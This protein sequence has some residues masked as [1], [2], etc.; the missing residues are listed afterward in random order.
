MHTKPVCPIGDKENT[1]GFDDNVVPWRRRRRE[2]RTEI[3]R[4]NCTLSISG[5]TC[6]NFY[7]A[8]LQQ[9]V[10]SSGAV[11]VLKLGHG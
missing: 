7:D 2:R 6:N 1:S 3:Q 4:A 5:G 11:A 8:Y 10:R 9:T